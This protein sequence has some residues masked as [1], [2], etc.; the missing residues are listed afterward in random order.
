VCV[1]GPLLQESGFA[2]FDLRFGCRYAVH[3]QPVSRDGVIGQVTQL[4]LTLPHCRQV[5][6]VGPVRPDCPNTGEQEYLQ[7]Q[8]ARAAFSK[9]PIAMA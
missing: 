5:A 8:G 3:L 1:C 9:F 2:V 7:D 6:V 4:S